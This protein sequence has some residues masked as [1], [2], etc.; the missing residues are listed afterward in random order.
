MQG[1]TKEKK[2][3]SNDIEEENSPLLAYN[4]SRGKG[5]VFWVTHQVL[6]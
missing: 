3:D 2:M 1:G 5:Y 4:I 6:T